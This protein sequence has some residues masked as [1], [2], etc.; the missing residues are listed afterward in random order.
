MSQSCKSCMNYKKAYEYEANMNQIYR[1]I[2]R[3]LLAK[4]NNSEYDD[5][6]S[7]TGLPP[8]RID[9]RESVTEIEE[10]TM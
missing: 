5:G 6:Q 1:C 8:T 10:D 9:P 3:N 4:L 2:L 7:G